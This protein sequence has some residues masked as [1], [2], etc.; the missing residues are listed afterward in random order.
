MPYR[1]IE[2]AKE[3]KFPTTIDGAPLTIK[4]VN[5]LAEMYDS[6][7]QGGDVDEPMAVA[8]AQFKKLYKKQD[9][10]WVK[11]PAEHADDP[12]DALRRVIAE[13]AESPTSDYETEPKVL[14]RPGK[15]KGL[16]YPVARCKN[17]AR[18][19]AELAKRGL[20]PSILVGH[21]PRQRMARAFDFSFLDGLPSL[22]KARIWWDEKAQAV[23]HTLH[24]MPEKLARL[25][26]EGR[27]ETVSATVL[28]E[29]NDDQDG[30][31][32]K[33][34]I[35][36]VS[37]LGVQW[38]G[39]QGMTDKLAIAGAPSYTHSMTF[40]GQEVE[41]TTIPLDEI[42]PLET[43]G[44]DED[45]EKLEALQTEVNELKD[46]LAEYE[47]MPTKEALAALLASFEVEDIDAAKEKWDAAKAELATYKELDEKAKKAAEEAAAKAAETRIDE[48]LEQGVKDGVIKVAQKEAEKAALMAV[49]YHEAHAHRR[50]VLTARYH[51]R[52]V[53]RYRLQDMFQRHE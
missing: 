44:G 12:G 32:R 7:K 38:P 11:R 13:I 22:G 6:I 48:T 18:H 51:T 3:A 1:T 50:A 25:I 17:M 33:D 30:T 52:Q 43:E 19:F 15:W 34:V 39:M 2:A 14:F 9:G 37:V 10:A 47:A 46:R 26:Q 5:H 27:Y 16:S 4:Q 49:G 21:D 35:P 28:D 42:E 31:T 24:S 45:M 23:M 41:V 53:Q 20:T 40:A 29:W 36:F 8:V